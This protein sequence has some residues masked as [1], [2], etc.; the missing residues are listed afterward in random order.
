MA[1]GDLFKGKLG[2]FS[3]RGKAVSLGIERLQFIWGR[4]V[5]FKSKNKFEIKKRNSFLVAH[6]VK[7]L[8]EIQET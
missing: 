1:P 4:Y 2:C 6:T 5:R 8:P 3:L 7:N